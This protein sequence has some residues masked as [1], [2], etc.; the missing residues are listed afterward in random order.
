MRFKA[1][2]E[3]AVEDVGDPFEAVKR[4][5]D[6]INEHGANV[7]LVEGTVLPDYVG[8]ARMNIVDGKAVIQDLKVD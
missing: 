5:A 1:I 4:L 7:K 3:V 2:I 8:K 6:E